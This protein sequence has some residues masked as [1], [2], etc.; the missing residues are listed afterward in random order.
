VDVLAMIR[1]PTRYRR[2]CHHESFIPDEL[3]SLELSLDARPAGLIADA[4]KV[5]GLRLGVRELARAEAGADSGGKPGPTAV[6]VLANIDAMT[7]VAAVRELQPN[8]REAL[9]SHVNAGFRRQRTRPPR[10]QA[11]IPLLRVG[12]SADEPFRPNVD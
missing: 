2:A 10:A 7:Y 5:E 1:P 8:W 6:E 11:E 4:E 12:P 3:A 9:A